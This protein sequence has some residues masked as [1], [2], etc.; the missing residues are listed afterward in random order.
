MKNIYLKKGKRKI[1]VEGKN[2]FWYVKTDEDTGIQPIVLS[3]FSEEKYLFSIDFYYG[4]EIRT[5]FT[6]TYKGEELKG[7]QLTYE[8]HPIVTPSL[9]KTLILEYNERSN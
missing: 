7:E 3:V 4:K 8:D 1:V 5:P 2:Y 6:F 9:V